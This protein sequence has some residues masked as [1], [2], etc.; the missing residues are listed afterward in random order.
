MTDENPQE[1]KII[2]DDDWKAEA[3]A[4]KERLKDETAT[5]QELPDPS[6]AELINIVVMQAMAGMG[7]L[8]GPDGQRMP[9]NLPMAKHFI[10]MLQVLEDKTKGNLTDDEKKLLDQVLYE[11]RMSFVELAGGGGAPGATGDSPPPSA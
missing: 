3:K 11:T 10:D 7:L 1:K 8:A 2:I 9:P 5:P 6:F 4:E